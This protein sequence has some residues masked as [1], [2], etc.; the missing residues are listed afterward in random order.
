MSIVRRIHLLVVAVLISLLVVVGGVHSQEG[1]QELGSGL[2]VSPTRHELTVEAAANDRIKLSVRNV[3]AAKIVAI[4]VINDFAADNET[5]VPQIVLD[6][7]RT[8]LPS[9]KPFFKELENIPVE[10][11]ETVTVE[12]PLEIPSD[13]PAGGYYGVIRFL[14]SPDGTSIPGDGQVALTASVASVVL[15]TVPG[16]VTEQL[17]LRNILF[18]RNDVAGTFF[19]RKPE[20]IG[21][22]LLNQGNGFSK[23][24]G[25]VSVKNPLG[26]EVLNYEINTANP[27]N[28]VLPGSG[29]IFKDKLGEQD[30]QTAITNPDSFNSSVTLPGRYVATANVSFGNGGEVLTMS[31]AFWY[32]PYWFTA[33]ILVL[34][35]GLIYAGYLIRRK[36]TTGNFK[37]RKK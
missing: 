8:D 10:P 35:A 26:N 31:K 5:G 23:P 16:D 14:A 30:P 28:N 37:R 20:E 6:D 25:S 2:S 34:L 15:I 29:R 13:T 4:P 32:I 1:E 12:V 21:I 22:Q 19:A 9:I 3:T 33:L 24:F 7:E 18:Y 27:R 17:Q 36:V 11:G